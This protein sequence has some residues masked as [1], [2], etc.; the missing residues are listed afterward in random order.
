MEIAK[1]IDQLERPAVAVHPYNYLVAKAAKFFGNNNN[2]K[3]YFEQN[4]RQVITADMG[5]S[6]IPSHMYSLWKPPVTTA[7]SK[8]AAST[9]NNPPSPQ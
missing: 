8:S 4:L 2:L 7:V 6:T 5:Y 3:K 1:F 9:Q